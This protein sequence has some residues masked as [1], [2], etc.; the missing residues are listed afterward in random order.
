MLDGNG[1]SPR[2]LGFVLVH[3]KACQCLKDDRSRLLKL[4]E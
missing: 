4:Q 1:F 3:G 2:V